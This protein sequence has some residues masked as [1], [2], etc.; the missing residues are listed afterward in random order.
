MD[1]VLP[2]LKTRGIP[3]RRAGFHRLLAWFLLFLGLFSCARLELAHTVGGLDQNNSVH[4]ALRFCSENFFYPLTA[5]TS[6]EGVVTTVYA[7]CMSSQLFQL[8]LVALR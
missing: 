7:V 3:F 5:L 1:V 6:P 4:T 8:N 2:V